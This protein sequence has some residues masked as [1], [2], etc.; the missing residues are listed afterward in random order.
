M[1]RIG[2]Y[3]EYNLVVSVPFPKKDAHTSRLTDFVRH[4]QLSY[5]S[6]TRYNPQEKPFEGTSEENETV[7]DDP[8]AIQ[9]LEE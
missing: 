7:R 9:V 8:N 5:R 3:P 6:G 2:Y 1:Y 4:C